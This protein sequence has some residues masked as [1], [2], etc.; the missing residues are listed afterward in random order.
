MK[1]IHCITGLTPD[2]AQRML[3]RVACSL[4]SMGFEN[5]VVSLGAPHPF[6]EEF[7]RKGI[8]VSFPGVRKNIRGIAGIRTLLA[9]IRQESPDILQG[10]MYHGNLILSLLRPALPAELPVVWNIRRGMDDYRERKMLTRL[11]VKANAR[12]SQTPAKIIYCTE[13]S[14][15]QHEEFG[16][17]R[18]RG[19]VIGNGFDARRFRPRGGAR[20]KIRERLGFTD[21]TVVIGNVGR[22]DTAKGRAFLIDAFAMI[23]RQYPRARLMLVGRGMSD[24]NIA[25][26]TRLHEIGVSRSVVLYGESSAIEEVYSAFDVLCSSSV[27]EGFPNVVAE[28]MLSELP[29]VATDTGN[30]RKLLEG[31]GVVVPSRDARLLSEALG[32]MCTRSEGV[33]RE[34]GRV[35]RERIARMYSLETV[36]AQY[37]QLYASLAKIRK[38]GGKYALEEAAS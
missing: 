12:L 21:E 1:I 15:F 31:V 34:M 37:A 28:A 9:L 32:Q 10:W 5:R 2:G 16:F 3:L 22:Y 14:R 35:S 17:H 19:I 13:E 33:R 36:A 26:K 7:E 29:C 27:A 24:D 20:E 6:G 8:P 18:G 23:H 25:L 30:I 38:N 4:N 11:T